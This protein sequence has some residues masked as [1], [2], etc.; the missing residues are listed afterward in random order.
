[1]VGMS[2]KKPAATP[3]DRHKPHRMV[4]IPEAFAQSLERLADADFNNLTDQVRIA[5]KEY[6]QKHNALPTRPPLPPA[7]GDN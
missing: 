2:K 4:R 3:A 5:L 1:M 7:D 6:L